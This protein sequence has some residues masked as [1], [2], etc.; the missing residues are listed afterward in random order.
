MYQQP[1]TKTTYNTQNR[2]TAADNG[3]IV[4]LVSVLVTVLD[5]SGEPAINASAVEK[6]TNNYATSDFNGVITLNDVNVYNT[7]V[8][9][10]QGQERSYKAD[11][12]PKTIQFD[13]TQLDTVI[14]TAPKPKN[15][16]WLGWL[17]LAVGVGLVAKVMMSSQPVKV[18][19]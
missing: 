6:G 8:I 14:V 11:A 17:G 12:V 15:Y 2:I 18:K 7:V 16:K 9:N 19:L 5:G 3:G 13:T 1:T 4:P 10:Y